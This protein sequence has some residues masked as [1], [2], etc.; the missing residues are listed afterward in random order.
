MCKI[1]SHVPISAPLPIAHGR[2]GPARSRPHG[3]PGPTKAL[4][5]WRGRGSRGASNGCGDSMDS[6]ESIL[7]NAMSMNLLY[8]S[9]DV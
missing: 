5:T 4:Q 8:Y 7:E 9:A 6:M 3:S 2:A 1:H